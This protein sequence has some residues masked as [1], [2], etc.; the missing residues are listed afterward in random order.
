MEGLKNRG[1]QTRRGVMCAHREP[2]Y[3]GAPPRQPLPVSEY[4]QDRGIVL[5]LYPAMAESDV[6]RVVAAL[7][8][9]VDRGL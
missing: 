7:T 1:I 5:P 8:E 2:A 9:I 3:A 4:L 6:D